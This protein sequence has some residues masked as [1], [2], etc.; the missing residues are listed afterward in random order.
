MDIPK[1][2]Y[3]RS[4]DV[5]VAYQVLG[6]GPT[7]LVLG[8]P[9]ATNLGV[10]WEWPRTVEFFRELAALVRLILFDK[11]GVGLSDRTVGI[12]P[13]GE[14]IDDIRAVM[15]AVGSRKA[16]LMGLSESAPMSMLFAASY[17]ERTLGL[18]VSGGFSRTLSAPDYPWGPSRADL[19]RYIERVANEWGQPDFVREEAEDFAPTYAGDPG[20]LGWLI[21]VFTHGGS[22]SSA[23]ALHRMNMEIDV[24]SV[25]STIRVPTLVMS[26]ET[27]WAQGRGKYIADRIPGAQFSVIPGANRFFIVDPHASRAVLDSI[28]SF[29]H[30]PPGTTETNRVLTTVLFTDIVGSTQKAA[31]LGDRAWSQLLGR[32][33]ENAGREV[34]Q[35][36]G[37]LI[38]TTGDGILATFDGPTRAVRCALGLRNQAHELALETRAGLHTG[39]CLVR[40]GDVEGIAV[41]IASRV[42]SS[43]E[44]GEVLVSG[45]VRD[46]S[47]GSDI[48][49]ESRGDRPLRGIEGEWRIYSAG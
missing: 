13:L 49:F 24:R 22:P 2:R 23:A 21:K 29:L 3:A 33:L 45:T 19:E 34:M 43:A 10:W 36:R 11:R 38:K 46:L 47:V 5:H 12:P 17:P 27:E 4:G 32:Y 7:D 8:T 18:I 48:R 41:H 28:R 37:R 9:D 30:A 26:E 16:V 39:E 14:R 44:G 15:D 40:A 25:L 31:E 20:F 6:S 1:V 35:F 42:S